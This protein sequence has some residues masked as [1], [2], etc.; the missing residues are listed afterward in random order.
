MNV[1]RTFLLYTLVHVRNPRK[2]VRRIGLM[3]EMMLP[4]GYNFVTLFIYSKT[5]READR[6][7]GRN[8]GSNRYFKLKMVHYQNS[9]QPPMFH[10]ASLPPSPPLLP[11]VGLFWL[12]PS[13]LRYFRLWAN[14][15]YLNF[16]VKLV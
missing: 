7:A 11:S 16:S 10:T 2:A 4:K 14:P 9:P 6:R 12:T 15:Y 8:L 3:T 13:S 5:Q 1:D